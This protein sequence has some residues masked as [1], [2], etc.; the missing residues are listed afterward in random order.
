MIHRRSFFQGLFQGWMGLS[1]L[2][3]AKSSVYA[4]SI[5][6][7]QSWPSQ[8]D[9]NYWRWIRQQFLIPPDEAYFN[10][11]TLGARPR[12]VTEAVANHMREIEETLAHFDYKPGHPEYF[13]GYQPQVELRKKA[14]SIINAS[15]R[16]IA[17][18]QNATMGIS[19]IAAGLNLQPGDEVLLTDQEHPSGKGGW[20]LREKRQGIVV[21]KL[22]IPIP[23]PNPDVVVETFAKAIT[24]RTKVIAVPHITSK[25]GV[26]LPVKQLCQ[27]GRER[28]I[29]TFIDGAQSVGHLKVDVKDI[30][31]DAYATSPH[32]WLLAPVG[33]GLL[34][35]RDGRWNDVWPSLAST[36]WDNH[37]PA[38][39]IVKFMANG[40]G[41][42]SLLVGLD[43]AL[44]FHLK[45]GSAR[46][47]KHDLDLADQLRNGLQEI[48]GAKIYSSVHPAMACAI[49]TWGMEGVTGAQIQDAL[50]EKKKIRV[51]SQGDEGVRQSAHIYNNADEINATLEVARSLARG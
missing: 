40:T 45:I 3:F 14:G 7:E 17:L 29:F 42:L 32:K 34:Y 44:D 46:V 1:L 41:N 16:E 49:V 48:K 36:Q 18:T 2:P 20:D 51:R 30:G 31:C 19:F 35:V 33:N 24:P 28:G 6:K 21:K 4:E 50:W 37:N 8:A 23:T 15:E 38:D 10:T 13:A 43:A 12:Q 11:G 22:P 47:Q 25:Y 39:G 26:V 5:Q 27:L 9:P